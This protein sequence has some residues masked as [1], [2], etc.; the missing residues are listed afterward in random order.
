MY[1]AKIISIPSKDV[2]DIT[3]LHQPENGLTYQ[4]GNKQILADILNEKIICDFRIQDV[5]FGGQGAPLVPIGDRL[6][7]QDYDYCLNITY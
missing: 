1:V 6:L 3:A 4:I 2:P 7:F 5:K